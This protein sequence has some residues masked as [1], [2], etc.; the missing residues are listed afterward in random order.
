M[1]VNKQEQQQ[2]TKGEQ[3]SSFIMIILD[4]DDTLIPTSIR[5]FLHKNFTIDIFKLLQPSLKQLQLNIINALNTL[6]RKL[7]PNHIEIALISNGTQKWLQN[8]LLLPTN[9][10]PS[11]TKHSEIKTPKKSV[12]FRTLSQYFKKHNISIHSAKTENKFKRGDYNNENKWILKYKSIS[13]IIKQKQQLLNMK[14]K[15]II[16]FGDGID[17]KEALNVYCNKK[18]STNIKCIHFH[19]IKSPTIYQLNKQWNLIKNEIDIISLINME[20][21]TVNNRQLHVYTKTNY[22]IFPMN[23]ILINDNNNKCIGEQ[24]LNSIYEYF[25][26]W[27]KSENNIYKSKIKISKFAEKVYLRKCVK[28]RNNKYD[29]TTYQQIIDVFCKY[30]Q[31]KTVFDSIR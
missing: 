1:N 8:I 5:Q 24:Q 19:L 27:L 9:T 31:F 17:E 6:K 22:F 11:E 15:Q 20:Y 30:E 29:G 13:Q 10:K 2:I 12:H 28:Q 25:G 7:S 23:N 16:S 3:Q 14:C 26:I 4:L 18:F 21:F